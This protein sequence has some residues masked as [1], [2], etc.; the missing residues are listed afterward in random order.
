M[1]TLAIVFGALGAAACAPAAPGAPAAGAPGVPAGVAA[2]CAVAVA[3]EATGLGAGEVAGGLAVQAAMP[4]VAASVRRMALVGIIGL[5]SKRWW[6]ACCG[7]ALRILS[8]IKET[9]IDV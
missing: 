4:C 8:D 7:P 3:P 2:V 9:K 6:R 1:V 5:L